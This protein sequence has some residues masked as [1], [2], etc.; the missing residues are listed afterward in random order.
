MN[1]SPLETKISKN[2]VGCLFIVSAPSGAGKTTLCR[3]LREVYTDIKYSVSHTTRS[4]RTGEVD[5]RDYHF[6]NRKRFQEL[7]S[8]NYWA[9]WAEVHGHYYGTAAKNID[10]AI[11]KGQDLLLDIDVQGTIQLLERYPR[12]VSIFIMTPSLKILEERLLKRATDDQSTIDKRLKNAEKEIAKKSIY[13]YVIVND[14][15]SKAIEE[16]VNI[17][18]SHRRNGSC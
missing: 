14:V 12:A 11:S 8:K 7:L 6:S 15:L 17:V 3:A 18:G 13:R 4:P 2:H 9:E 5:G 10:D 16:L 1:Q